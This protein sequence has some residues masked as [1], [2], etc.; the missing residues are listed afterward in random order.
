MTIKGSKLARTSLLLVIGLVFWGLAL[1][2]LAYP[3]EPEN[4]EERSHTMEPIPGGTLQPPVTCVSPAGWTARVVQPGDTLGSLALEAGITVRELVAANCQ[5]GN[6]NLIY[7]GQEVY[8]PPASA[9]TAQPRPTSSPQPYSAEAEWPVRLETKRSST[10]RVSLVR[11]AEGLVPTVEIQGN[12]AAVST[13]VAVGTVEAELR[14]AFGSEY[15]PYATVRLEGTSFDM[16][17][18]SPAVQSLSEPR[19]SWIWN[20]TSEDPGPQSI[21]GYIEIEWKPVDGAKKSEKRQIWS[22]HLD[23]EVVQPSLFSGQVNVFS[24]V[25]GFIGTGLSLPWLYDVYNRRRSQQR[26]RARKHT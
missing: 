6:A 8:L 16:E 17:L 7:P 10:I 26:R 15:E 3:P 24:L 14:N 2:G 23:I 18:A 19:L 13:P 5:I 11:G 20:I 25:S 21:D 9:G 1:L 4:L 22:F 12:T